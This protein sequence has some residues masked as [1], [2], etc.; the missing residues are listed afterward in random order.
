MDQKIFYEKYWSR[1]GGSPAEGGFALEER[2]SF[3]RDATLSLPKDQKV[4][5][6]GCGK[7]DF[8]RYLDELGFHAF[9]L[10]LSLE[11]LHKARSTRANDSYVAAS[12]EEGLPFSDGSFGAIFCSEVLEHIFSVHSALSEL[13]R[14]L[15]SEGVLILTVPYHGVA[16]DLAIAAFGFE[17]HFN[18][19]ISHIRFFTRKSLAANLNRSGFEIVAWKGIGRGYPFWMSLGVVAKKVSSAGHE[20]EIMG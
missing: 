12:L 5:D 4:I 10:D 16:K 18:P 20:P 8:V 15:L 2:R 1:S 6:V 19:N 3:L 13:N 7:G 9:G 17:R 14:I 11:A